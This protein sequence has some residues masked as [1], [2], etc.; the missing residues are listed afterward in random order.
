MK[1]ALVCI[2]KDEDHYIK[3]W[4]DYHKKLGFDKIFIYQNFWRCS[5]EDDILEKIEFD[6]EYP[7]MRA[8]NEFILKYREE[9]DWVAFL[10]VDEFIVLKKHRNIKHLIDNYGNYGAAIGINWVFFGDNGLDK[11][12][13]GNYS[14]IERF[15]KRQIGVDKHIKSIVN[16]KYGNYMEP[17]NPNANIV[18]TNLH[19]FVGPWNEK[20]D[21]NW[22]QINHYFCK[23]REEFHHKIQKGGPNGTA[24]SWGSFD[25]YNKNDIEDLTALNFYKK[26]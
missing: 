16:L 17:H 13:N 12:E 8:Y 7:Q 14:V 1:V 2:A 23:T 15:T 26:K 10:D 18:D 11:V 4:V 19:L 21:D 25:A 5:L 6:I 24:K 9:Y 20:G 22:V 3:E